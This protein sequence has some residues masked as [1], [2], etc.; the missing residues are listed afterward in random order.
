MNNAV[1]NVLKITNKSI[2]L[3]FLMIVF[4]F[5]SSSTENKLTY[6]ETQEAQQCEQSISNLKELG[7]LPLIEVSANPMLSDDICTIILVRHGKTDS[8]ASGVVQGKNLDSELAKTEYEKAKIA[9]EYL[10]QNYKEINFFAAPQGRSKKTAELLSD[11]E[12]VTINKNLSEIDFGD[13]EGQ[14]KEKV[15]NSPEFKGMYTDIKSKAPGGTES[16]YD[17]TLRITKALNE[18]AKQS[19]GRAAAIVTSEYPINLF[20]ALIT[21]HFKKKIENLTPLIIQWNPSKDGKTI[22]HIFE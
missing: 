10:K 20:Y 5:Q 14:T 17:A 12:K 11:G 16:F 2:A 4:S 13:F 7:E 3:L 1:K 6:F 8:N 15:T 9:S 18:I 22:V 19:T 21:G